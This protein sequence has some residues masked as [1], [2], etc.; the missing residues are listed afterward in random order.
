MVD[1]QSKAQC[2]ILITESVICR[3]W[4]TVFRVVVLSFDIL[5]F[6]TW[7]IRISYAEA[8]LNVCA[9]FLKRKKYLFW[10]IF[11]FSVYGDLI[12]VKELADRVASYV[13]LCT[14]YWWL[15][16]S[17]TD[18]LAVILKLYFLIFHIKTDL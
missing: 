2:V 10:H 18:C 7:S 13:H 4:F 6:A 17:A 3:S 5:F 8:F 9:L 15:R 12:P 11:L 14:L 16:F 1:E